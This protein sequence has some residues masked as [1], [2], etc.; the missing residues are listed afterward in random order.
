MSAFDDK[1]TRTI[2]QLRT[3]DLEA[4]ARKIAERRLAWLDANLARLRRDG[5]LTP[6]RAFEVLFF[7]QMGLDPAD[8]PVVSE[9]PDRIEWESRNRCPLLEAC[10]ALGLDTRDICRPV[11]EEATQAFF[12][13]LDPRLRFGRSYEVIRP[14]ASHCREWLTRTSQAGPDV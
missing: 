5:P 4:M 3:G 7:E 6:R 12:S 14:H 10:G 2:R 11:N 1:V 9:S 13:R 8:L